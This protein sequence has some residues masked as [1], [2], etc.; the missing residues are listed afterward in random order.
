MAFWLHDSPIVYALKTT[1]NGCKLLIFT[2]ALAIISGIISL[3]YLRPLRARLHRERIQ[4]STLTARKNELTKKLTLPCKPPLSNF[5]QNNALRFTSANQS[6]HF[7]IG[8]CTRHHLICPAVKTIT[9]PSKQQINKCFIHTTV[10]GQF[11]NLNGL[12][13]QL[14]E[15]PSIKI[16]MLSIKNTTQNVHAQFL[17]RFL[18]LPE[19]LSQ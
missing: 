10:D 16:K 6:T 13:K 14:Q 15:S 12:I 18:L 2:C 8:A 1:P 17:L 11:A 3:L 4:L 7:F 19:G 5:K 9:K